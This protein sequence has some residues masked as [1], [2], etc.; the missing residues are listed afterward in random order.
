ML[1]RVTRNMISNGQN[2]AVE[3]NG[4][5]WILLHHR[6]RRRWRLCGVT[7]QMQGT[8]RTPKSSRHLDLASHFHKGWPI[9]VLYSSID[10]LSQFWSHYSTSLASKIRG[11]YFY[12]GVLMVSTRHARLMQGTSQPSLPE[13]AQT[14]AVRLVMQTLAK[15]NIEA[16]P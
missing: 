5:S 9:L 13:P 12:I 2:K 10:D 4:S 1:S 15:A 8:R 11:A 14:R 16:S 7:K 3:L 6:L